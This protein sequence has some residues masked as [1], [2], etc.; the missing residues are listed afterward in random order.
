MPETFNP[1]T[2]ILGLPDNPVAVPVKLP[3]KVVAVT[4]PTFCI[5]LLLSIIVVPETL[6]AIVVNYSA[7]TFI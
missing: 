4:I 3:T 1:V 5:F 7:F 2:V 6:I